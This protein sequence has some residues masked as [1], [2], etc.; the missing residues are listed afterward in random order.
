MS[1]RIDEAFRPALE[2]LAEYGHVVV[3]FWCHLTDTDELRR[4]LTCDRP[5]TKGPEQLGIFATRSPARPNP[6]GIT[7]VSI[8]RVDEAEGVIHVPFIDAED[9][10]P[11]LDLKPYVPS[12]DRI[13]DVRT[14]G[15]CAHWPQWSEDSGT[16]D[17]A[18]EFNF[19]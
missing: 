2:G 4:L 19:P 8:L 18:A 15:W 10:T 13:R 12:L 17:W 9:G 14:P 3:V 11:I 1:L 6:I 7:P 5:Y 16:F